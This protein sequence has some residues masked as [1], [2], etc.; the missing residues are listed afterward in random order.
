MKA[1]YLKEK[2]HIFRMA[3]TKENYNEMIEWI[4]ENVSGEWKCFFIEEGLGYVRHFLAKDEE[5]DPI[6]YRYDGCV[7][8]DLKT[9]EDAAAFKLTWE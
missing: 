1:Y 7:E 4:N 6:V 5:G 3:A 2:W 9:D 8:V